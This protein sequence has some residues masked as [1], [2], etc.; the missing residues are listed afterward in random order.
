M[1]GEEEVG[2][3]TESRSGPNDKE[4]ILKSRGQQKETLYYKWAT[5]AML[6]YETPSILQ[7]RYRSIKQCNLNEM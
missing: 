7:C 1:C 4:N 6:R 2:R 3:E 5:I